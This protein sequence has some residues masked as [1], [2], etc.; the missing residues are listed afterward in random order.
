M[1]IF[2]SSIFLI[3][4]PFTYQ[5]ESHSNFDALWAQIVQET[6]EDNIEEEIMKYL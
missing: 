4:S 1:H 2:I 3:L 5:M 6:L